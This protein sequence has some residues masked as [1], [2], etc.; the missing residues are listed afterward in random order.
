LGIVNEELL[1][2]NDLKGRFSCF[3][4]LAI[5]V[6]AQV[7]FVIHEVVLSLSKNW[8]SFIVEKRNVLLVVSDY[9]VLDWL[10]LLVEQEVPFPVDFAGLNGDFLQPYLF[11][12]KA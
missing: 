9:F 8:F 4:E 6:L 10:F 12:F 5:F 3:H 7:V 11:P 1:V 2:L